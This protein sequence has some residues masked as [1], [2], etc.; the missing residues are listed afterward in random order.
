MNQLIF[1]LTYPDENPTWCGSDTCWR[2]AP[3]LSVW[4]DPL[5]FPTWL[6]WLP[7]YSRVIRFIT[8]NQKKTHQEY[9][10]IITRHQQALQGHASSQEE[11]QH[12]LDERERDAG[13]EIRQGHTCQQEGLEEQEENLV[14]GQGVGEEDTTVGKDRPLGHSIQEEQ[15]EGRQEGRQRKARGHADN[16]TEGERE[17]ENTG[18]KEEKQEEHSGQEEEKKRVGQ[19]MEK[20]DEEQETPA[21]DQDRSP[22]HII[23]AFLKERASRGVGE[24]GSFTM[25]QLYHMAADLFGAG[26]ETTITTLKWHLLNMALFP[27]VQTRVQ[28]ELDNHHNIPQDSPSSPPSTF[29]LA[30]AHLLPYTQASILETQRLR[31]ILPLG[32]PHGATQDLTINGYRVPKGTMLLPLLWH[33]HHDPEYWPDPYV[34]RP[35]RFLGEGGQLVKHVAF[36]P[37]QTGR[38]MCIGDEFARMI[39]FAFTTTLLGRLRV[40]LGDEVRGDPAADPVCGI[41]LTPRPFTLTFTPRR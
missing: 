15:G 34:Y 26:S 21:E 37:F 16:E 5:N 4:L 39:L 22:Q 20:E 3:N 32:I 38:R 19:E 40:G 7:R 36:M 1:G 2:K 11:G 29:T 13:K 8:D 27:E 24:E 41:S 9:H 10:A 33:I 17:E 6:R 25:E 18:Q 31:S 35:E 23:G 28:T 30:E 14:V 12:G